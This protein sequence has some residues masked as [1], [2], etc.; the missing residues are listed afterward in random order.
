MLARRSSDLQ[1]R[2]GFWPAASPWSRT[3]S[4]SWP[5]LRVSE[6]SIC[7]MFCE[8]EWR[9]LSCQ[10]KW[11]L[12]EKIVWCVLYFCLTDLSMWPKSVIANGSSTYHNICLCCPSP[13]CVVLCASTLG[14]ASPCLLHGPTVWCWTLMNPR[15]ISRSSANTCVRFVNPPLQAFLWRQRMPHGPSWLLSIHRRN[16]MPFVSRPALPCKS[17]RSVLSQF[18]PTVCTWF[19]VCAHVAF[20]NNL[21]ISFDNL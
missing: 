4:M 3:S 16:M 7:S 13:L 11:S 10:D 5:D 18:L 21:C 1:S 19:Y 14:R 17:S 8:A 20:L 6:S 12:E 2:C 9:V 15:L